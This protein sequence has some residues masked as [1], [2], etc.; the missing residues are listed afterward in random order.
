M[1]NGLNKNGLSKKQNICILQSFAGYTTEDMLDIFKPAARRNPD[2]IIIHAV[3]NQEIL[4]SEACNQEF[5][6]AGDI[7]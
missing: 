5:F 6:R 3:T 2:A 4:K 1:A 7:S